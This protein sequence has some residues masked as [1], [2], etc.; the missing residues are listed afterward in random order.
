[1]KTYKG[2]C[3]KVIDGD[4]IDV[5]IDLGFGIFVSKRIRLYGIDT[6]ESRTKNKLEKQAG[7]LAKERLKKLVMN[8]DLA[9][10]VVAEGGKFGRLVGNI[11]IEG[12]SKS[13]NEVLIKEG[14]AR[15]YFGAKRAAWKEETLKDIIERRGA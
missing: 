11:Y 15:Q 12:T 1:M 6:P 7:L 13:I 8:K 9:I 3:I 4:T 2:K 10:E 5:T 14:Y